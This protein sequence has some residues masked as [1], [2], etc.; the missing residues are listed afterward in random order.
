MKKSLKKI[1]WVILPAVLILA[2]VAAIAIDI[3]AD[4]AL[5]MGIEVAATKALNVG[6][7][8]GDVDL[9]IFAGKL[10]IS[11]LSVNN[12]PGYRY[13]KLLELKSAK[14]EVD[15]RALLG[16]RVDIK[17][18]KL[19]GVNIFLEQRGVSGNN[20]Q[21]VMKAVSDRRKAEGKS[22]KD[23]KKI[24]VNNIEITDVIVKA[25]LLPVPG[26][27]DTITFNLDPIV[28]TDL[29]R[30][31]DLDTAELSRKILAAIVAGVADK[32]TGVLPNE[33]IAAMKSTL[34][35]TIQLGK[36][37]TKEGTKLLKESK[38]RSWEFAYVLR[39]LLK[40]LTGQ[41]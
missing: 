29:G 27:V 15:V 31:N 28:M 26:K 1:V 4:H 10:S 39:S 20:L 40:K 32:G 36:T 7:S 19:D 5:K 35:T 16:E 33:M 23:G 18:I 37:A 22:G 38:G 13:D 24:H 17:E 34:G 9:Q 2:A 11:N 12:P 21:D 3:F 8:V 14:I 6:V 30:D 25:K 41:N